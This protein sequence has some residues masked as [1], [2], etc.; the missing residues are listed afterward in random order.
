VD[1]ADTRLDA[2][3]LLQELCAIARTLPPTI[4]VP[5]FSCAQSL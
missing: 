1:K 2:L 3:R 4:R 5:F